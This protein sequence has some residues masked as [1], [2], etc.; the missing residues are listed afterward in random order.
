MFKQQ[1][2]QAQ[3]QCFPGSVRQRCQD[4]CTDQQEAPSKSQTQERKLWMWQ[5]DHVKW[6]CRDVMRKVKVHLEFN[7]EKDIKDNSMVSTSTSAAKGNYG[8]HE[9]FAESEGCPGNW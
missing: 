4:T 5:K 9:A 3:D 1:F 8:K 6:I 2:L 7:Q